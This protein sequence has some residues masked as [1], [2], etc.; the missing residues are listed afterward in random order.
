MLVGKWPLCV[1]LNIITYHIFDICKSVLFQEYLETE[2]PY[3]QV[4]IYDF[5]EAPMRENWDSCASR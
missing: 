1:E 4:D 5:C 2:V 3:L